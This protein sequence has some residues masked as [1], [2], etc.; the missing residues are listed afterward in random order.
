MGEH[1]ENR[2]RVVSLGT[3]KYIF[4]V[5]ITHHYNFFYF[6]QLTECL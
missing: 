6:L 4:V 3:F 1:S 5:W 2:M